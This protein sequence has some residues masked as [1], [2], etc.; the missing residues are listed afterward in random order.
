MQLLLSYYSVNSF[1]PN[2]ICYTTI[3]SINEVLYLES[4]ILYIF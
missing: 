1:L 4:C 3:P 2:V